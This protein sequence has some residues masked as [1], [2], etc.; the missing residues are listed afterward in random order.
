V[1]KC[2]VRVEHAGEEAVGV[3]VHRQ[4]GV[5]F[6]PASVLVAEVCAFE[7]LGAVD[8]RSQPCPTRTFVRSLDPGLSINLGQP[9]VTLLFAVT[10]AVGSGLR[11]LD[12]PAFGSG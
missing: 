1:P 6:E 3:V 7:A 5:C 11:A 10:T 2:A 12:I 4:A 9:S 8:C